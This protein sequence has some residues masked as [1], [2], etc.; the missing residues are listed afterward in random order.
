M[1]TL[2][3]V[4]ETDVLVVG[5]GIGGLCAAISAAQGG[6]RVTVLEKADSRRSGSGAT[7]NDHFTCYYPKA[8][9]NDIGVI[10]KELLD[11]M[12]GPAT[13]QTFPCVFWSAPS[14]LPTNGTNGA[15][16]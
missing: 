10:L 11:S 9:G 6:A 13:T 8:H 1:M 16:T 14:A 7:G 5:G 15:S 2:K 12:L 3:H 4:L